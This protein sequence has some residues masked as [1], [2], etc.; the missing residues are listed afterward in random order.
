M[1]AVIF[2][3]SPPLVCLTC[4]MPFDPLT[5]SFTSVPLVFHEVTLDF[6]QIPKGTELPTRQS[7]A[8]FSP[9]PSVAVSQHRCHFP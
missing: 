7:H 3:L 4:L 2:F 8:I 5:F 1:I 6:S 9:K